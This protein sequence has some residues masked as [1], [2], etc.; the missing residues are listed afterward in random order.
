MAVV[1]DD[2]RASLELEANVLIAD[3]PQPTRTG[4]AGVDLGR[5][6]DAG[7]NSTQRASISRTGT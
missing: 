5:T 3:G 6:L 2:A 4:S 1:V 7:M